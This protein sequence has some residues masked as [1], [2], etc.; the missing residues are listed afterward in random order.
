MRHEQ[1]VE[2]LEQNYGTEIPEYEITDY[3]VN[4][5]NGNFLYR[6]EYCDDIFESTEELIV[7]GVIL[8]DILC[9]TC[10]ENT[11]CCNNCET[12]H[13]LDDM[14]MGPNEEYYCNDCADNLIT[15]CNHCGDVIWISDTIT[16]HQGNYI[17]NNCYGDSY[18]TC[19]DCGEVFN[20]DD[21]RSDEN[22]DRYFCEDC[23]VDP[24][25][26]EIL[27]YHAFSNW[28]KKGPGKMHIGFELEIENSNYTI[29]NNTAAREIKNITD[30]LIVCERDRS[31]NS[32]FEIV[33]HP[34]TFDYM[35]EHRDKI[36][37]MLDYLRQ[38]GYR[39]HDPGTCGLH[40]HISRDGLGDNV[41][42]INDKI[43]MI[44]LIFETFKDEFIAFSRRKTNQINRWAQFLSTYYRVDNKIIS[45]KYVNDKKN[46]TGR[47]MAVNL[48]P[49]RTIEFRLWRGT[50]SPSTFFATVALTENIINYVL[51][52]KNINGLTWDKLLDK[53]EELIEYSKSR[54][55]VSTTVGKNIVIRT[56]KKPIEER[57]DTVNEYGI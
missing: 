56:N 35:R 14:L 55:I 21:I 6:C 4:L 29:D 31:L 44:L 33:S 25:G 17:C 16:T 46:D 5:S 27:E 52:H 7:N 11:C 9:D 8:N 37:N 57:E 38:N 24:Y 50:L 12:R 1:I 51:T 43:N 45:L 19:E 22:T 36:T 53:N 18:F 28:D 40:F 48:Q 49:R 47:Y 39:S 41:V 13:Y 32:G 20:I 34:M 3:N 23:F 10:N 26:E 2:Y 30:N 54:N 42:E 15:Q